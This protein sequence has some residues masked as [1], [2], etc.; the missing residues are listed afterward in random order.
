MSQFVSDDT[1]VQRQKADIQELASMFRDLMGSSERDDPEEFLR[2]IQG[3]FKPQPG[4][5]AGYKLTIEGKKQPL[6]IEINGANLQCYYGEGNRVDV[7]VQ[8]SRT[9]MENIIA[10]KSTFQ[11]SFMAGDM[12]MK[13]DFKILRALDQVLLFGAQPAGGK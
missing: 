13:G 7:E 8:L 3:H 11:A 10:G 4:V 1:Y 9:T 6:V 5:A 2:D 12:R